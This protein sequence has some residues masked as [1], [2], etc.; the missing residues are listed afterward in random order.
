MVI[1]KKE[2]MSLSELISC[3][4]SLCESSW[5][6]HS[7][8][9]IKRSLSIILIFLFEWKCCFSRCCLL[10]LAS[11]FPSKCDYSY[12]WKISSMKKMKEWF[13]ISLKEGNLHNYH[14]KDLF[15]LD[16]FEKGVEFETLDLLKFSAETKLATNQFKIRA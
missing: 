10:N 11:F 9:R 5:T 13:P 8:I 15:M 16:F 7:F 2:F 1:N 12:D 4:S 3:F 6:I 14:G